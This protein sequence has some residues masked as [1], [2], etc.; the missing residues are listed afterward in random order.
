MGGDIGV[1][2]RIWVGGFGPAARLEV[3]LGALFATI[4]S[5]DVADTGRGGLGADGGDA[6]GFAFGTVALGVDLAGAAFVAL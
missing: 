5:G 1:G 3:G 4:F 6:G 2:W